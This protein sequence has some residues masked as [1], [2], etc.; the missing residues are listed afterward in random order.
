[1]RNAFA[2]HNSSLNIKLLVWCKNLG[3]NEKYE[4]V[5]VTYILTTELLSA[6]ETD[7]SH[8][9]VCAYICL[10]SFIHIVSFTLFYACNFDT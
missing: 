10:Y 9:F 7:S 8:Q 5:T 3:N 1:M 2:L 4:E 6:P